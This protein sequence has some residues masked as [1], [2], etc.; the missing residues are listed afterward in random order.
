M[1]LETK[2]D[3]RSKPC[4]QEVKSEAMELITKKWWLELIFVDI[5]DA[6][7]FFCSRKYFSF[8]SETKLSFYNLMVLPRL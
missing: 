6:E 3:L 8:L 7:I 5:N 1:M 4:T 2:I